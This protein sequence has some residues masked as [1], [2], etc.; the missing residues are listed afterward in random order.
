MNDFIDLRSDTVTRP[1]REMR[2]AM[3]KAEVGDDVFGEDPTVITLEEKAAGM[4]GKEAAMF[5]PSGTMA[6]QIALKV[7]SRAGDEFLLESGAHPFVYE[8]CAAAV[9]SSIMLRPLPGQRGL[10]TA[11]QFEAE[12]RPEDPHFAPTRGVCIEN[13]H[14]RGGGAVYSLDRVKAIREMCLRHQ[15]VMHMD[16][17][18]LFNACRA[19]GTPPSQFAA[20]CETV[21]FCLSKGLGA[22][23]GSMLVSDKE[24]IHQARRW[25]KMMGGGMRQAGIIAAAGVYALDHNVERLTEDHENAQVLARGLAEIPGLEINPVEVETNIVVFSIIKPQL[26]PAE[27]A[28]RARARGLLML[29]FGPTQMRAVTH[30][31][32]DRAQV[33]RAVGIIAEAAAQ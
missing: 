13:T 2:E 15:L 8:S 29:P 17:A 6:N 24:T 21:S 18:R 20:L 5:V 30:L 26:T 12:I 4:L 23:V 3:M 14:N 27:L 16:G 22:P 33:E 10:L 1:S 19:T 32:V 31:D 28:D 7:L 25:R 9:I 11:E